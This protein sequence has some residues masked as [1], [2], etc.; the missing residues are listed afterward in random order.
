MNASLED[1]LSTIR[2]FIQR[3]RGAAA[4]PISGDTRLL[5]D[6]HLDS[7]ALAELIVDLEKALGISLPDGQLL[8]EDFETPKVL[9][10]R[11]TDLG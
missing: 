8:P 6:G 4:R 3:T 5:Q 11:L 1:V 9:F 2:S 10:E 7:F